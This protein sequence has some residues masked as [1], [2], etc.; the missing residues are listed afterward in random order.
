MKNG[1]ELNT[2][3]HKHSKWE[4]EEPE[5]RGPEF[6]TTLGRKTLSEKQQQNASS[7]RD[8]DETAELFPC[9][10]AVRTT[11]QLCEVLPSRTWAQGICIT[12]YCCCCCCVL[13]FETGPHCIPDSLELAR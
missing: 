3:A 8:P 1:I 10:L 2:K 12:F 9:S 5:A 4:T 11:C 13:S 6:K 7:Q